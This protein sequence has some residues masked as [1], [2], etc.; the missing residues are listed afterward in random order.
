MIK[1]SRKI[2]TLL[3]AVLLIMSSM[4]A[5]SVSAATT[6]SVDGEDKVVSNAENGTLTQTYTISN[7]PETGWYE[8]VVTNVGADTNTDTQKYYK[9][10]AAI[11]GNDACTTVGEI[12]A[13]ETSPIIGKFNLTEGQTPTVTLTYD[14]SNEASASTSETIKL[15]SFSKV[16]PVINLSPVS[17][18]KIHALNDYFKRSFQKSL[19]GEEPNA[20]ITSGDETGWTGRVRLG[21]NNYG[22][23][24]V[25]VLYTTT[26]DVYVLFGNKNSTE[27]GLY[28]DNMDTRLKYFAPGTTG[29]AAKGKYYNLNY[30]LKLTAG[31]H[32]IKFQ[33]LGSSTS[34]FYGFKLVPQ[35]TTKTTLSTSATTEIIAKSTFART[36]ASNSHV[37]D[38]SPTISGVYAG[39]EAKGFVQTVVG[40]EFLYCVESPVAQKYSLDVILS[41][42]GRTQNY[43]ITNAETGAEL[44]NGSVTTPSGEGIKNYYTS[45]QRVGE[46][47]LPQGTT[48]LKIEATS[49]S[50]LQMHALELTPYIENKI[51]ADINT[52]INQGEGYETVTIPVK[53]DGKATLTGL[54]FEIGYD[55]GVQFVSAAVGSALTAVGGSTTLPSANDTANPLNAIWIPAD[56]NTGAEITTGTL[57]TFIFNVPKSTAKD[58]NFTVSLT[59]I[60]DASYADITGTFKTA[61]GKVTVKST[62][63][64]ITFTNGSE[65]VE[66]VAAGTMVLNVDLN[67]N[68][69]NLVIFAIYSENGEYAVMEYSQ[70]ATI[71]DGIATATINSITL[72]NS[73]NYYAKA[74]VWDTTSYYGFVETL[75]N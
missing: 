2:L 64:I 7:V 30:S 65:A 21:K 57:A 6:F 4:S 45:R 25:N 13:E 37:V 10:S 16:D 46:I 36:V 41:L 38:T 15:L 22:I 33:S 69:K 34:Y 24:K 9:I 29:D 44:C 72:D 62:A 3:L 56:I 11:T 73:K 39:N 35:V 17:E 50:T 47:S 63:P 23:Y 1:K 26:Y 40:N 42:P 49:G 71:E 74:F 19:N 5:L 32:D 8:L 28:V 12:N 48:L 68:N 58:Y 43:K 31:T 59:G 55:D 14:F 75:D 20:E 18:T 51:I 54:Q 61:N 66:D 67:G 27:W 70:T 52:E 60:T 53:F